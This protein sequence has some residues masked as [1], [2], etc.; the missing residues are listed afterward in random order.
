MWSERWDG[1]S[2]IKGVTWRIQIREELPDREG[3]F[4]KREV[5]HECGLGEI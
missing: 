2:E 4:S 3:W 1:N 5:S